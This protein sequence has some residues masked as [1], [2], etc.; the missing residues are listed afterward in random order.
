MAADFEQVTITI[1]LFFTWLLYIYIILVKGCHIL[2]VFGLN[3]MVCSHIVGI[4]L[5]SDQITYGF[6]VDADLYDSVLLSLRIKSF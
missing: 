3:S 4:H 5:S 1:G 2:Y 6:M